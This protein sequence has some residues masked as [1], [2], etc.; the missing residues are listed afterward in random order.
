MNH[1]NHIHHLHHLNISSLIDFKVVNA[2]ASLKDTRRGVALLY[3]SSSRVKAQ[4]RINA[5]HEQLDPL[6]SV[7]L[8]QKVKRLTETLYVGNLEFST[9][10][11]DIYLAIGGIKSDLVRVE[12]VT[13][14]RVDGRSKNV[15]IELSWPQCVPLNLADVCI[16]R[17]GMIQV[18]S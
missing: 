6:A 17:S 13:I 12:K 18:N 8:D 3:Q 2:R 9:S 16:R 15:F 10:V 4:E 7:Y 5:A 1:K 11:D 14:P